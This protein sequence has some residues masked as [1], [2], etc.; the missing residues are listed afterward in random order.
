MSNERCSLLVVD[1][2]PYIQATLSSLLSHEFDVLTAGTARSAREMF[3]KHPIDLIL[4]D[5][6]MPR[7]TGVE[8]LEWVRT[9]SPRT[10]RM[11][12]TGYAELEEAVE[13]INRGHV[14]HYIFKPWN[15]SDLLETLRHAAQTFILERRNR[16]LLEELKR[17]NQELEAR[18]QQRTNELKNANQQLAQANQQLAEAN[19]EL[20][21]K[22][23]MLERLA[24]TDP[25]T[26]LPNRRAMDRMVERELRRRER[27][28]NAMSVGM[29]DVDRFKSINSKY[30][31][32]G[33]DKVLVEL[34]KCLQN[35]L[36]TVDSLGRVGGEEFLVVAPETN[37]DGAKVLGERIRTNVEQ[38]HFQYKE[39]VIPV[40]VSVGLAV[41]DSGVPTDYEQM[42]HVAS[43]ALAQAK[44]NGRNCVVVQSLIQRPFDQAG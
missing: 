22:N 20:Q 18:V 42:K 32:P 9:H 13:A 28:P 1:D 6:R 2:E 16:Q 24:L 26:N 40:T 30:L 4:T 31:L 33:G 12:M 10:V 35:S 37:F 29:I 43:A 7:E 17:L 38:Y 3:S 41:A 44:L 21:Q 11:L 27:Y 34:A 8:L 14:Y 23:T 36:R 19:I 5:Q 25:L 39:H 15:T